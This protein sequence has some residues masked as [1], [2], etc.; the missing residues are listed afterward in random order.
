M[1]RITTF[2]YCFGAA[3]GYFNGRAGTPLLDM[4]LFTAL[5]I[6]IAWLI[7]GDKERG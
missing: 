7:F 2:V 5:G 1:R 4:V 3:V 6:A